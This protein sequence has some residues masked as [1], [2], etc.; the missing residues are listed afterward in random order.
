MNI[1]KLRDGGVRSVD[2]ERIVKASD[3]KNNP[4]AIDQDGMKEVLSLAL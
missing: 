4:I 3:N 2:F 1:P